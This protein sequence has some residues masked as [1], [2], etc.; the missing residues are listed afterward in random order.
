MNAIVQTTPVIITSDG[1]PLTDS[2]DVAALFGRLH[3]NV[4]QS[5]S[6]AETSCSPE[7]ARLNFQP[8]WVTGRSRPV[9][10]HYQL[11]KDGFAFAVLGF[12]GAAAARFKEAY[13][14]EFN[15]MLGELERRRAPD[16]D[17]NTLRRLL[18]GRIEVLEAKVE[19]QE[20]ALAIAAPKVE[21]F[22][23]FLDGRSHCNLRTMPR[24][25]GC[26]HEEF[27]AWIR[28]KGYIFKEG[29][30]FQP[31]A[32]LRDMGYFRV[33]F[34]DRNGAQRAQT[35]VTRSGAEFLRQRWAASKLAKARL[36]ARTD[37]SPRLP[38]IG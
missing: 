4:L 17:D 31:R 30:E 1:Q 38:G 8:V 29:G 22:D 33:I 23:T 5:I 12:A 13:I 15:R 26:G 19:K 6:N 14:A 3:K 32:D 9:L 20:R 16:L 10:S 35:V 11:T 7:F 24:V 37:P 21:A 28:D 2:R 25:L 34:H 36:T 27:F 18:L